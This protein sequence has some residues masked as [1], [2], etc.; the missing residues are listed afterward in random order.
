[1][2]VNEAKLGESKFKDSLSS[3]SAEA[4]KMLADSNTELVY[5]V[6]SHLKP[7]PIVGQSQSELCL[8]QSGYSS[9]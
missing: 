6:S 1:M 4:E 8:K 2:W 7:D 9:G 3:K 5:P